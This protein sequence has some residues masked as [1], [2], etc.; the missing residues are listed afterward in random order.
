MTRH[1]V[2]ALCL[3]VLA[4][5]LA[6]GTAVAAPA[7]VAAP[8]LEAPRDAGGLD[9]LL[10]PPGR[11][12]GGRDPERDPTLSPDGRW[13]A[14]SSQVEGNWDIWLRDLEAAPGQAPRR[15]T[16]HVAED[17][18]PRFSLDGSSILF[19]SHREDAAGDVWEIPLRRL[20]GWLR[21]REERAVLRRPG[22]QDHPARDGRGA[23]VWD[24]E[25]R[26]GRR[27]MRW[28]SG[29]SVR[30]LARPA[31]QPRPVAEG[32]FLVAL[33]DSQAA[34]VEWVPDSLLDKARPGRA[35]ELAWLPTGPLLDVQPGPG[36]RLWAATLDEGAV[37]R[38]GAELALPSQLWLVDPAAGKPPRPLLEEGRA[39][40]QLTVAEGRMVFTEDARP[41]LLWL[42]NPEGRFAPGGV[43]PDAASLL[44]L[45]RRFAGQELG[46]PLLQTIQAEAPG[47][48]EADRAALD[49]FRLL[50]ARGEPVERLRERAQVL[51]GWLA[52]PEARLRLAALALEAELAAD[53]GRDPRELEGLEARLPGGQ[54]PG[55]A[56]EILLARARRELERGRPEQALAALLRMDGLP[57][58][59]PDQADGLA[60][61]VRA[62][63]DM[64]QAEASRGT[65]ARL[66]RE[67]EDRP[68]LLAGWLR[69]DLARLEG[70]RE[71]RARLRLRERLTELGAIAPLRLALS[72]EL[73]DREAATGADGRSVALEDLRGILADPPAGM[74]AF[75]RRAWTQGRR[76]E[77][78]LLRREGRLDEALARLAEGD[79]RL[80]EAGEPAL[81][82][83]LRARR[84][85]WLLE[86]ARDAAGTGDWEPALADSRLALELDP[87]E[88]RAWRLQLEALARLDRLGEAETPLRLKLEKR[89]SRRGNAPLRGPALRTRAVETWALGLLLSWRAETD[90]SHLPESDG[91]LEQ[92]LDLDDRLAPA[93]L[94]LSWNLG[95][96]LQLAEGRRGGV[97]GLL[98]EL[99]RGR[100]AVS[101]L[102]HRGLSRLEDPDEG[103]LRDRAILLAERGL[104]W[105]DA[106]RDPDLAAAL[107]THLGNLHFSLGE[108]GAVRAARAWDQRLELSVPF[109]SGEERLRFLMNLG[110]ARQW[111]GDLERAAA[112][113]DSALALATRLDRPV[114][115]MELV[116]RLALLAQERGRPAEALAWQRQALALEPQPGQRSLLWRN[117]ALVQLELGEDAEARQSLE[118]ARREAELGEWPLQPEQNWLK[119]GILGLRVPVWNFPGL[120]TGQGR[121]DWGPAEEEGLRQALSDELD[122]RRGALESRLE[123]LHARRRLLRRQ[124]DLDG[125][126]RIDLAIA[127]ELASLGRW[128][129]AASRF[130]ETARIARE[131]E[132]PGPEGRA[133]EGALGSCELGLASVAGQ[134]S[135]A[136]ERLRETL[137]QDLDALLG[138]GVGLL[139]PDARLRLELTRVRGLDSRAESR[140]PVG[141]LL[142]R[143]EALLRL[144]DLETWRRKQGVVWTPRQRLGLDL[145]WSRLL[146]TSGDPVAA[147]S[148]LE[149]WRTD[150]LPAESALL[151][152]WARLQ[153]RLALGQEPDG[154]ELV[155]LRTR[156]EELP[157]QP[158]R[159]LAHRRVEGLA[160]ELAGLW[161]G[162][163]PAEAAR[164]ADWLAWWEGRRLWEQAD[165]PFA[166]EAWRNAWGNLRAD[167]ERLDQLRQ[168]TLDGRP[169]DAQALGKAREDLAASREELRRQEGSGGLWGQ[170]DP[171]SAEGV[172]GWLAEGLLPLDSTRATGGWLFGSATVQAR[173]RA[174]AVLAPDFMARVGRGGVPAEALRA[175]AH[176]ALEARV[177]L[178]DA[179]LRPVPGA[180]QASWLDFG[181]EGRVALR[182]LMGLDLPG[183]TVVL[184]E[185]DWSHT[186]PAAWR[187]GWLV[188]ERWLAQVG[189]RRLLVP[190]QGRALR[191]AELEAL[192]SSLL[193]DGAVPPGGWWTLGAPPTLDERRREDRRTG[194]EELV[195][196][197]NE[198][199]RLEQPDQAWR[200]YRRALRLASRS[201]MDEDAGR[202]ARLG[203]AA[204]LDGSRPGEALDLLLDELGRVRS[205]AVEWDKVSL[206]LVQLADLAGR[207]AQA[208]SLWRRL[209]V[210][211][212]AL[213][214]DPASPQPASPAQLRAA[215]ESR[216]AGLERRGALERAALL[217]REARLM[218][219]GEDPRRALFLAR[220]YLDTESPRL[221]RE[222]LQVPETRWE[223][224]DSLENL[225]SM[226]LRAQVFLRLGELGEAHAWLGRAGQLAEALELPPARRALHLQRR[227]DVE[228]SLGRFSACDELLRGADA[229]AP[230]DDGRLALLLANTRGLLATELDEYGEAAQ[231]FARAQQRGLELADPLDL[232]AV[233]VNQARLAARRGAWLESL[234]ACR[235]A[236]EQ[237]SLSGSR[238][239]A[240]ATLRHRAAATRGLLGPDLRLAGGWTDLPEGLWR[241][242][243]A[244]GELERL[245]VEL[246]EGRVAA[247]ELGDEREACRLQLERAWSRLEL[248]DA[249]GALADADAC[250]ERAS[251]LLFRS[252]ELEA[253]LVAGRALLALGREEEGRVRLEA[254]L[255]TAEKRAREM[256]SVRFD[257]G[258]G[259]LQ[260]RL[261]DAL[262]DLHA[263]RGKAWEA[264]LASERGRTLGLEEM[265]ARRS[266]SSRL[267]QPR[268]PGE[269]KDLLTSSLAPGQALLGWHLGE[270]E[271]WRF[272]WRDGEL[273]VER[274]DLARDSLRALVRLHRERTLGF[275][276]VEPTGERLASAL[277]PAGWL[278]R[279]PARIWLLPQ[280]ELHE[281]A[282]ESLVLP[283]GKWLG[284][285]A[286]FCRSGSLAEL[287]FSSRLP[288]GAGPPAAWSQPRQEGF[289]TLEYTG[290]ETG[291][292]AR[293][294]PD[295]QV[296][297]GRLATETSVREDA[298]ARRVRHFACHALHDPRSPAESALLLAAGPRDD[299]RVAAPEIAAC[300]LPTG[301]TVLS[302]CE[303]ALGR[304]GEESNAALPRAFL[305][306]GSRGVLASLWKVDDLSTAVLVKHLYR[307]LAAGLPADLALQ[308]AQRAVRV[309]VHGHP[310][311]WAAFCLT[312]Q[313]TPRAA[314]RAQAAGSEAGAAHGR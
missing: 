4:C 305:A 313:P 265:V 186:D 222:C 290:L 281:L 79:G 19:I 75:A 205:A 302:A 309:W 213:G 64:D 152:L 237:D 7:P 16:R 8:W 116:M 43:A 198:Y 270:R 196:L 204:A 306:A 3:A 189:V 74:G 67:H 153:T 34:R 111:A 46:L 249:P 183:E 147:R 124:G 275:L 254:A 135:M 150:E 123:G 118:M 225:E 30:E 172:S 97:K 279:V 223:R 126:L 156:L 263:G 208:D 227:A 184:G 73:A 136:L 51:D 37:R 159:L 312:G 253:R 5:L 24:E 77:A 314:E 49:E 239:R 268:T 175:S 192:G 133:L 199:R 214:L 185:V 229:L 261:A 106:R 311:H 32:V 1:P 277:L 278:E 174:E 228:W 256:A 52:G 287:E 47:T 95:R 235:R 258:R 94:T 201:G 191:G 206:R 236:G 276:G 112:D 210:E 114:Q 68:E 282:F 103:G 274:I 248:D 178:L 187:E 58:S 109:R 161:A 269:L 59:L 140:D 119:L 215:L 154:A 166:R 231:A 9:S 299:G 259:W 289:A 31:A 98:Q 139:A 179:V 117:L 177:L 132:L 15:L 283:D 134:D 151:V 243:R 149:D 91:W 234:E 142:M 86:R 61:R 57:D 70:L 252:E 200:Q 298:G 280:A 6:G 125:M 55:A 87:L 232:S 28:A 180:P 307:G 250:A 173:L 244:R 22:A 251:R 226:E 146:A 260:R 113:L 100:E 203:V 207:G 144:E 308:E 127:R 169:A 122:G 85:D 63:E 101:R 155:E 66:A 90:P 72:V 48:P 13:L 295:S 14:Y 12:L 273:L 110:A 288:G 148:K 17:R 80:T 176:P 36:G 211:G 27:V 53:P 92:A 193:A 219:E 131:A 33:P 164:A 84:I 81:A 60:L 25:S 240:L 216:L 54:W 220:L 293:L 42:E 171:A 294:S 194:F 11:P 138:R 170:A 82:G 266:G 195:R 93:C 181:A 108:F 267:A 190:G 284:D 242:R 145:A 99:G 96:E 104:R 45:A 218:P 115:R 292:L 230:P 182:D 245:G 107:H 143:G 272:A 233:Y 168:A 29:G 310:A 286:A 241:Q 21:P 76:L 50:A 291:E 165:P 35:R 162:R 264:L 128:Q 157:A 285:R 18:R 262:V 271:G 65:L 257:P 102:R 71:T 300:E 56:A 62:Y 303:T 20:G 246:E 2:H 10:A 188:L 255:E 83:I 105:S 141:A 120:Y 26:E 238:R 39:P 129:E 44:E 167:L 221:A 163:R 304:S 78:E 40:R 41:S 69:R 89:G 121:L 158:D 160:R 212:R 88:T 137:F 197:G 297:E 130:R 217:A 301:L 38:A 224:L 202:L 209:V 296:R 247:L 23:L